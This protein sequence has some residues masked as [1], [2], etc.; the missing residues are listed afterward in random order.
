VTAA[1][2]IGYLPTIKKAYVWPR[3]ENT[4]SWSMYVA[5]AALNVCAL[6]SVK[7]AIALPPLLGFI[8]SVTVASLLVFPRWKL[9][10]LPRKYYSVPADA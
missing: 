3:S 5:A 10:K 6:T 4:L 8:L 9:M 7:P 2:F 1:G